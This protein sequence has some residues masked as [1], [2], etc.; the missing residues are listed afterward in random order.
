L[1][2]SFNPPHAGHIHISRLARARLG[3]DEVWWLVSPQNPLKPP[4]ATTDLALRV[5]QAKTISA[6][7]RFITVSAPE[8]VLGS[9]ATVD[10][11]R[12]LRQRYRGGNFVWLMGADN[13]ATFHLW[14]GWRRLAGL[15]PIAV[16]D[17]PGYRHGAMASNA[18]GTMAPWRWPQ[19]AAAGLVS[20]RPPAW[21]FLAGPL[22]PVSSTHLRDKS[23]TF[24]KL[25]AHSQ[26]VFPH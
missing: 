21:I 24:A 22:S 3:L 6:G 7:D 1:G 13:L 17:R 20:A 9:R 19:S 23:K 15:L 8:A 25:S 11:A 16:I 2:G 5:E 26:T 10:L 12:W 4:D 14:A 18:A